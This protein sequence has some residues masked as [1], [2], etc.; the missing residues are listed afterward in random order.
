MSNPRLPVLYAIVDVETS[1]RAGWAARDLARAYL[2]GGATLL[3][4]RAKLLGSGAFL[5]L[6]AAVAEDARAGNAIVIVNDRA[7]LAVLAGAGGVH[8][9]QEDLAPS[10]VRRIIGAEPSLGFSTH[11]PDQIDR[12]LTEPI[13]YLA[14]GPVF[15]TATKA[16]GYEEVGLAA[17][18]EAARR[19]ARSGLPVV[20]IGGIT[21]A[22]APRVIEAG[23][24]AV[25][26]ITDLVIGNPEQRVRE[27]LEVLR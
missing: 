6:A 15:S 7:D 21:L 8:V 27:Y 24:A 1:Q 9:G 22:T 13:S 14:I 2:S 16:T 20:A 5:D 4:L 18:S 11:T 26:V 10:D 25:A 19:A 17:V 23:A 3:Q 12:A